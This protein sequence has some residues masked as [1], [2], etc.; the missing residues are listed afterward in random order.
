M[1]NPSTLAVPY[2]VRVQR[3]REH[4][5]VGEIN[6]GSLELKEPM[7]IRP[8]SVE[9][10]RECARLQMLVLPVASAPMTLSS[11]RLTSFFNLSVRFWDR[12]M[13]SAALSEVCSLLSHVKYNF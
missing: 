7:R 9:A 12:N 8:S 10:K 3:A 4:E 5:A 13:P 11:V 6:H 1:N 2:E